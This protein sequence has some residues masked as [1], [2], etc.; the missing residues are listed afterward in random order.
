MWMS[1]TSATGN[2]FSQRVV[3]I[4]RLIFVGYL[5]LALALHVIA[6]RQ[7]ADGMAPMVTDF[8]TFYAASMTLS[9]GDAAQV[10]DRTAMRA[11]ER[12]AMAEA[13]PSLVPGQLADIPEFRWFYPPVMLPLVAPLSRL[14]YWLAYGLWD[15]LGL[16]LMLAAV[17]RILPG[18]AALTVAL[19][20]PAT[21]INGMFGQT[22]FLVAGLTGLGLA[23]LERRP[24]LAGGLLAMLLVKPHF[25]LLLPLALLAGGHWL[26]L[27]ATAFGA[28]GLAAASLAIYGWAPWMAFLAQRGDAGAVL[29]AGGVPWVLMPTP[30]PALRLLG[31]DAAVATGGQALCSLLAAAAVLW[32]W[33]RPN[34]LGIKAS[35]LCLAAFLVLP[36]A[37]AYD[38]A[39][40]SLPLF[41]LAAEGKRSRSL[42]L[43]GGL[44]AMLPLLGPGMAKLGL[45]IAP[46]VIA[47]LLILVLSQ[48]TSPSLARSSGRPL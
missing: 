9:R 28:L 18:M 22:G 40:L 34:S 15:V 3:V 48:G 43:A 13:Y 38:L 12:A 30:W 33:R 25:A 44:V 19:A 5:V 14:P 39:L 36:F 4:S 16:A 46:V 45:P 7:A 35:A 10:Y 32:C 26:A 29:E 42:L 11:A 31:F 17:W 20:L 2:L 41:W 21:F 37:H 1:A 24:L 27:A 23:A 8:N 6:A 47:W